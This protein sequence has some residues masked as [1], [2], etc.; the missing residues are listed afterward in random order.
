MLW[1][2]KLKKESQQKKLKPTL[3]RKEKKKSCWC[4]IHVIDIEVVV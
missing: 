3:L 1:L 2:E 4:I